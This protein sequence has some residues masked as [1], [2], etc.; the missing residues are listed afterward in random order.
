MSFASLLFQMV[1]ITELI[2]I[3]QGLANGIARSIFIARYFR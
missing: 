2:T 1:R 3:I